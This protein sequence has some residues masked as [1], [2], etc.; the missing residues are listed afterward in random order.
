MTI[1]K[2]GVSTILVYWHW[3]V[4]LN[5]EYWCYLDIPNLQTVNLPN[6]FQFVLNTIV[7]SNYWSFQLIIDV[8]ELLFPKVCTCDF[9]QSLNSSV[10]SITIPKW[11]CNDNNYTIF[12]FS[13]FSLLESIEIGN[14]SFRS[15]STFQIE[16]LNQDQYQHSK[17]KDWINWKLSKSAR[18]HLLSKS[19]VMEMTNRNHFIYW[20]VNHW[21]RLKLVNIVS[22]IM[23]VNLNW[24]I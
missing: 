2:D 14:D 5:I 15:V 18:I 20:I 3:K 11:T 22:V 21:N 16:G 12:D 10:T 8:S 19:I 9:I 24:R 1:L 23:E 4:F 7:N 17:S 13:R 6:A